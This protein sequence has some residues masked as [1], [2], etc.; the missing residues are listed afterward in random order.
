MIT[1]P[2]YFYYIDISEVIPPIGGI[3]KYAAKAIVY[4][5]ES[6]KKVSIVFNKEVVGKNRKEA[7][8]KAKK[9]A[10]LWINKQ[11]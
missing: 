6:G 11:N 10:K 1:K 9:L 4:L 3:F 2:R 5:D 8:S 7:G